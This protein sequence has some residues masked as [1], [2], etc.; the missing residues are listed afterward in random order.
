[1]RLGACFLM[2]VSLIGAA[3]DGSRTLVRE[4][5]GPSTIGATPPGP[6]TAQPGTSASAIPIAV[7]QTVTHTVMLSDPTCDA[8]EPCQRFAVV[9]SSSGVLRVH[10]KSRGPMGLTLTVGSRRVWGTTELT[11]AV[12]VRAGSSYEISVAIHDPI[13]GSASQTFELTTSV[14]AA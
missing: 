8:T 9:P 6:P 3:C 12:T 11:H 4:V 10:V 7:G 13:G 5:S 1:M 14:E 2:A